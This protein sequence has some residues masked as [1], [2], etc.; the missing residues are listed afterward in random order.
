M[1]LGYT[2]LYVPD[3]PGTLK[4]C[5]AAFGLMQDLGKNPQ[6]ASPTA[7]CFEIT[8]CTQKKRSSRHA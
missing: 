7:P 3:V 8:L 4:F 5:E 6:A 1:Q 2:I